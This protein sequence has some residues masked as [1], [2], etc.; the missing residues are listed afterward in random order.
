MKPSSI[1][2]LNCAHSGS[3]KAVEIEDGDGLAMGAEL[4]EGHAMS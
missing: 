3:K 1:P 2:R 4:L